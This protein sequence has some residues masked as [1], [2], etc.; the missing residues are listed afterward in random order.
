LAL[1]DEFKKLG[2]GEF[3]CSRSWP[4]SGAGD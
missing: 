2:V 4:N 3:S 1:F